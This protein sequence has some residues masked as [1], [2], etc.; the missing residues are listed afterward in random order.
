M[1]GFEGTR[2][3]I[4]EEAHQSKYVVHTKSM[5]TYR[6]LRKMYW[7]PGVKLTVAKLISKCLTITQF[8]FEYHV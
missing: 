4:V 7:W 8:K 1:L 6:D 2:R 5:K 3:M